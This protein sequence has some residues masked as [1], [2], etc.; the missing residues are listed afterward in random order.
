MSKIKKILG[1]LWSR[2][3]NDKLLS[4]SWFWC[5]S[6]WFFMICSFISRM[7][8]KLYFL[9]IQF[10][11]LFIQCSIIFKERKKQKK[12]EKEIWEKINKDIEDLR[13]REKEAWKKF[14]RKYKKTGSE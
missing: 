7:P 8:F 2:L 11:C 3:S 1:N 12:K 5:G 6:V 10:F 9:I 14:R 13:V 4:N